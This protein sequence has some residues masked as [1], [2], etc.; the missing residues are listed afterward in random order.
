MTLAVYG[1]VGVGLGRTR[2]RDPGCARVSGHGQQKV[3]HLRGELAALRN[4]LGKAYNPVKQGAGIACGAQQI[5]KV[6][7]IGEI[8]VVSLIYVE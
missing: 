8:G 5:D 7:S 1:P 3:L 6:I 4:L 2:H